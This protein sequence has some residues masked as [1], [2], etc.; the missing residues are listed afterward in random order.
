MRRQKEAQKKKEQEAAENRR[1]EVALSKTAA[2]APPPD[3]PAEVE[4]KRR[5]KE[6]DSRSS[7]R[8]PLGVLGS[9]APIKKTKSKAKAGPEKRDQRSAG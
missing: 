3:I 9:D 8:A 4:P 6:L 5:T 2:V 1:K 7:E